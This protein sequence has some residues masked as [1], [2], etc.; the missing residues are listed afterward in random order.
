MA[1]FRS[2]FCITTALAGGVLAGL[3]ASTPARALC[4]GVSGSSSSTINIGIDPDRFTPG[5]T[6][7]P[8]ID[9]FI[10][11]TVTTSFASSAVT[12]LS[13]AVTALSMND[14]AMTAQGSSPFVVVNPSQTPNAVGGGVWVR[15]VG[16]DVLTDVPA[17]G[18]LLVPNSPS[19][20]IA[21]DC[22]SRVRQGFGGFQAGADLANLNLDGSGSTLSIGITAGYMDSSNNSAGAITHTHFSV[23]F[24][25]V[26]AVYT[27]GNFFADTQIRGNWYIGSLAD[28]VTGISGQAFHANGFSLS[29]NTGYHFTMPENWFIEPSIG[30]NFSETLADPIN[31]EFGSPALTGVFFSTN[32]ISRFDSVLGRITARVGTDIVNGAYTFEPYFSASVFHEF[33]GAIDST[34]T[35]TPE[36]TPSALTETVLATGRIGTFGQF[37]GGVA[38]QIAGTG[39]TGFV[40]GDY[41]VG[42]R[43]NGWTIAGGLRYNFETAEAKVVSKY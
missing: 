39:L 11:T 27:H 23:P 31:I 43:F 6:D 22:P 20:S 7:E 18:S 3:S 33:A 21:L 37:G 9:A 15:G 42:D 13:S 40:R 38:A 19:S 4:P 14:I 32:D 29:A 34:Q 25:G 35:T 1:N 28:Q 5:E 12:S 30:V 2:P 8:D 24:A 41:R 16:G 17:T 10:V 36:A 26:Y